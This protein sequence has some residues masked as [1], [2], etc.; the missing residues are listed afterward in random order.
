MHQLSHILLALLVLLSSSKLLVY[1]HYCQEELRNVRLFVQG[2]DCHDAAAEMACP[3]HSSSPQSD[4]AHSDK[5]CCENESSL[6]EMPE[7]TFAFTQEVISLFSLAGLPARIH[8]LRLPK[9]RRF[10]SFTTYK[11]PPLVCDLMARLQ[12]FRI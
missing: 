6:L 12:T 3:F 7:D 8:A 11:P 10:P 9:E 1:K 2:S 4:A 5:N